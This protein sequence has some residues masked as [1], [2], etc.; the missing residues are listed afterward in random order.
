MKVFLQSIVAQLIL[1]PYIF[2]RGYQALPARKNWRIPYSLFFIVELSLLFA[3]YF[4]HKQLPDAVF[5]PIMQ[6]CNTWYVASIYITLSLLC[7]EVLRLSQHFWSWFPAW[8]VSYWKEVKLF[9]FFF[10]LLGVAFLLVQ[11]YRT[12]LYPQVKQVYLTIPK[13]VVGRDSLRIVMMSDLHIGE[14][15]RKKRVQH[16]V[17]LSNEQHPDI[18]V[19]V[20]DILDY[21]SRFAEKARI[22][23]DLR[24]LKAPLGTYIV[25]GNHEYRANRNA[26]K[27]WLKKTGATILV[28][29]VVMPDS[30][31]YL[32][33]RDD[34]I[35][36]GRKSLQ[37]LMKGMDLSK[38]VIVLDHQP[39]SLAETAMNK[40]DLG[41]HGHTHNGQLW[42][43]PL[44]LKM[45]YECAY[46]YYRKG[47]T[48][49]YVSSGIGIAGPPFRIG[50]V[51]EL[52]V[53]HVRFAAP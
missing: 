50:T 49:Y 43:Y 14:V 42:P 25:Y 1:N 45:V 34:Y 35:H 26:K 52:V 33:G 44:L 53:L 8:I 2:I 40:A 27:K 18:V 13:K 19:L 31:F 22:E 16:F 23:D 30:T 17:K 10:I 38:P 47:N 51:S 48:Q 37:T 28:D 3:G 46:G 20:G 9:F 41:L 4:F 12:V 11:G 39:W 5:L 29:S 36:K 7:L 6:I 21:E 32:I 24:Q 15:I